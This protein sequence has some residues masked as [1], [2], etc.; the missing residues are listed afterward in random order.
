M[1]REEYADLIAEAI[2][3]LPENVVVHRLTGDGDKR[4]L[5]A[6]DWIADKK[7]TLNLINSKIKNYCK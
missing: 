2:S 1:S 4:I 7:R 3:L 6:P 5:L